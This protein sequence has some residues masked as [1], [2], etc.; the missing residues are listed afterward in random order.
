[1]SG[2]AMKF[3]NDCLVPDWGILIPSIIPFPS[4]LMGDKD[5]ADVSTSER[6]PSPFPVLIAPYLSCFYH[7]PLQLLSDVCMS[8]SLPNREPLKRQI[9]LY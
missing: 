7:L 1:M 2:S 9:A 8:V 3:L 5:I 6:S 4:G